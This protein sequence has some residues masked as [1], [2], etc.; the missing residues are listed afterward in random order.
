ML[1]SFGVFFLNTGAHAGHTGFS[2]A[3]KK[4]EYDF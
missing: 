3:F 1:F 2:E 4:I